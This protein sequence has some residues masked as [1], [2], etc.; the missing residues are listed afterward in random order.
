MDR[1]D[2]ATARAIRYARTLTP[3]DLRAVHF[4]IDD[5]VT[6]ELVEEWGRLGLSRLPLDI[7][8]CP[9]RRLARA[10]VELVADA[11]ADGDTECTVLLPRRSFSAAWRRVLHDQTADRISAVLSQVPHVSATIVPYTV[12]DRLTAAGRRRRRA[13]EQRRDPAGGDGGDA[14]RRPTPPGR[15]S[16]DRAARAPGAAPGAPLAADRALAERA[17]GTQPIGQV[18]SASGCGWPG[19]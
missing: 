16:R 11:V 9:D 19:G 18:R 5:A 4:D 13:L 14:A 15:P 1:L 17:T 7:V 2:L 8:E 12:H 6:A 3:D 10:A